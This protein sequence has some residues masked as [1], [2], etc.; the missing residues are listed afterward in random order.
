MFIVLYIVDILLF[1]FNKNTHLCI[2]IISTLSVL[3]CMQGF[4][5]IGTLVTCVKE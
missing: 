1:Y 4:M 3:G 5:G 2:C